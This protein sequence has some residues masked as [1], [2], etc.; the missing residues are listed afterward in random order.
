MSEEKKQ[1]KKVEN[2][3]EVVLNEGENNIESK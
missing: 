2:E 1:T 3:E